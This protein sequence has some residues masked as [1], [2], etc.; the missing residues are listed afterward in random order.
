VSWVGA[1]VGLAEGVVV[2]L[3]L[4]SKGIQ[5]MEEML[6]HAS[7]AAGAG[8]GLDPNQVSGQDLGQGP[9]LILGYGSGPNSNPTSNLGVINASRSV[10]ATSKFSFPALP[11]EERLGHDSGPVSIASLCQI[12]FPNMRLE[13]LAVECPVAF[14]PD[15]LL[16]ASSMDYSRA[17]ALGETSFAFR[18][19]KE[20]DSLSPIS[21]QAE[22][23]ILLKS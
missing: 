2:G 20:C 5:N 19:V 21:F 12:L 11:Q 13:G 8:F 17:V 23:K 10:L 7:L 3:D 15:I 9:D 6:D 1:F 16:E 14:E 4:T 18:V 22:S